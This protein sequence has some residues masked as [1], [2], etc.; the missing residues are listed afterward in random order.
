LSIFIIPVTRLFPINLS[1][2]QRHRRKP[3]PFTSVDVCRKDSGQIYVNQFAKF[4]ANDYRCIS[5]ELKIYISF[6]ILGRSFIKL[7]KRIG[8]IIRFKLQK[9]QSI[10]V[11]CSTFNSFVRR[12]EGT[13]KWIK[14][15]I[16]QIIIKV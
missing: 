15:C 3:F 14:Q 12:K 13:G 9:W 7:T 6:R 16:V 8:Y 5:E 4:S 2:I 10:C 1:S 11:Q